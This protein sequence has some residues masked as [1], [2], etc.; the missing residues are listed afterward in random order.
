MAAG[1]QGIAARISAT[2]HAPEPRLQ[3]AYIDPTHSKYPGKGA[4]CDGT[5]GIFRVT[6]RSVS[7][8]GIE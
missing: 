3:I 7:F 1:Q 6:A 2:C 4:R 8:R 5:Y